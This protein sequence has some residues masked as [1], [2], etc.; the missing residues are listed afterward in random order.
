MDAT[1]R[2]ISLIWALSETIEIDDAALEE[3]ALRLDTDHFEISGI[4]EEARELYLEYLET[5]GYS[6]DDSDTSW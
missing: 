2:Y 6:D 5:Q 4:I 3:I 1:T